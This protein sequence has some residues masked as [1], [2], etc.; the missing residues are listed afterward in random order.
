MPMAALYGT[1]TARTATRTLILLQLALVAAAL[2]VGWML[3]DALLSKDMLEIRDARI[4]SYDRR[5]T[6]A[7]GSLVVLHVVS[8]GG[9]YFMAGWARWLF[10]ATW[11]AGTLHPVLDRSLVTIEADVVLIP[12][13]I[14]G[15]IDGALLAIV[16]LNAWSS[17]GRS[18]EAGPAGV[19]LPR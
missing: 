17:P 6:Y 16:W 18:A 13:M 14:F 11:L 5:W 10:T 15:T 12:T 8:L 9:L 19:D 1:I 3:G 4:A 2:V 7:L